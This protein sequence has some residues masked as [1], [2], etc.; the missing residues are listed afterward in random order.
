MSPIECLR[1]YDAANSKVSRLSSGMSFAVPGASTAAMVERWI[2]T[3]A[4]KI[5]P[6]L[7]R[8]RMFSL[9]Q[10]LGNIHCNL[11]CQ[12]QYFDP[13]HK[14][15]LHDL[16]IRLCVVRGAVHMQRLNYSKLQNI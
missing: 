6:C 1:P 11:L 7:N 13:L 3:Y 2:P 9:C 4:S 10:C 8:G 12:I 14:I 5:Q 15:R 16:T